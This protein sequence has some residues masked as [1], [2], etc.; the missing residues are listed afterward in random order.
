[1]KTH[2]KGHPAKFYPMTNHRYNEV[3]NFAPSTYPE[4]GGYLIEYLNC[5]TTNHP[6]F[7]GYID[8]AST[9]EVEHFSKVPAVAL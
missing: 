9:G 5:E 8:W 4:Q 6:H 1:M 3:R 7:S 2:Y